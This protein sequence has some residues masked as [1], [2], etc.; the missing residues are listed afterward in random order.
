MTKEIYTN[1]V[2]ETT[3]NIVQT[4][5]ESVRKKDIV[6]TGLRLYDNGCIGVSGA[7]GKY[8]EK[9]LEQ[10][11]RQAL[12]M[13]I[14]Y[15][16][17]ISKDKKE[18]MEITPEIIA[19]KDFPDEM[20]EMLAEIRD[21]QPA[22]SFFNK[23]R[24]VEQHVGLNNDSGLDLHFHDRHISV[25][26]GI[27]EKKSAN[28]FDAFGAYYGRAYDRQKVV[29][30][31]N[32]VC[33]AF[34]NP[35]ELPP[36]EKLPVVF[37][38]RDFLSLKQLMLD[39]H[40]QRFATGSSLLSGKQGEKVFSDKF[41]LYQSLHP[42]ECLQPFFDAEGVVNPDYRYTLIDQGKVIGPYTD[43][44]TAAQFNLPITGSASAEYDGVPSLSYQNFKIKESEK[45]LKE[46][47]QGQMGVFIMISAGGDFTS[48]GDFATPVQLAF[49]FDGEKLIGKLPE[50]QLASSVYD[51]FGKDFV[52]VGKNQLS[53]L[54]IDKYM[55][56]EMKV[57]K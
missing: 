27:K 37:N 43:K 11:A 30:L 53:E 55:V 25:E 10:R 2:Q 35:V 22:F 14:P 41:T 34:L 46:L 20:A 4:A 16:F 32:E 6:R 52:G 15:T 13:K 7:I 57:S 48:S 45:T 12:E 24:L 28:L 54:S 17:P 38:A 9:N 56:M 42:D 31:I 33:N 47:L 3:L 51:M 44:R 21:Q 23:I 18:H 8:D 29:D 1:K 5:V 36:G 50:L 40:G 49:L 39:L 19:D 26:L